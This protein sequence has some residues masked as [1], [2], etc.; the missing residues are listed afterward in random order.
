M[1]KLLAFVVF[2]FT[3]AFPVQS[4]SAETSLTITKVDAEQKEHEI[5]LTV[6]HKAPSPGEATLTLTQPHISGS[7]YKQTKFINIIYLEGWWKFSFATYSAGQEG[8]YS[9]TAQMSMGSTISAPFTFSFAYSKPIPLNWQQAGCDDLTE[10]NKE[11]RDTW[12]YTDKSWQEI[13]DRDIDKQNNPKWNILY[14]EPKDRQFIGYGCN[15]KLSWEIVN[16]KVKE[17]V[18]RYTVCADGWRSGSRGRG[19]CSWHGGVSHEMGYY[20]TVN[21]KRVQFYWVY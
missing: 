16:V 12:A 6:W 19:T 9:F 20:K 4:A 17:F 13:A 5:W 7:T 14:G 11:W 8:T 15:N 21:A 3:L 18:W 2:A 10:L 1:K